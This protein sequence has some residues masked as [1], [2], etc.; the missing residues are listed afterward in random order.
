MAEIWFY[1]P[2]NWI[3]KAVT[4]VTRGRFSHV[5]IMHTVADLTVVT[6]AHAIKGVWCSSRSRVR[7]P[8]HRVSVPVDDAWTARWMVNKWGMQYGW[9]DALA[10]TVPSYKKEIDRRGVIC[11]EIVGSFLIDAIDDPESKAEF[12]A[13]WAEKLRGVV[14]AKISPTALSAVLV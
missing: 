10:F 7:E 9:I 2:N 4:A 1:E 12:P 3:G 8:Q 11:T 13:R 6:E 14:L 5:S